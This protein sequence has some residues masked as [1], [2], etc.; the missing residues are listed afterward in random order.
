MGSNSIPVNSLKMDPGPPICIR[1]AFAYI[2][3]L[4]PV[5]P[6]MGMLQVFKGLM[7]TMLLSFG[8]YAFIILC[9]II[10]FLFGSY[11]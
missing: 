2:V 8:V 10:D 9:L 5:F 1:L 3:A 4:N 7:L 11:I 6:T